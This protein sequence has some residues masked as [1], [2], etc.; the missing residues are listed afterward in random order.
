[1]TDAD[2]PKITVY[3]A[4]GYTGGLVCEE[5]ARRGCDFVAAG[6]SFESLQQLSSR[7]GEAHAVVPT[8]RSASLDALLGDTNV[9]INCAGPF[10]DAGPPVARAALRNDVH[11]LDTTGEQDY[12][13]WM[14]DEI[15][16]EAE[17][18]GLVFMP[19][20]AFEYATGT[21]V[22]KLAIDQGADQI[23]VCYGATDFSTS[24][25]TKMSIVR[26][27]AGDGFSWRGGRIVD[28]LTGG[29]IYE[30][31][32]PDGRTHTGAWMPG[33][34][35]ILVP[36]LAQVE[37]AESCVLIGGA[38]ASFLPWGAGLMKTAAQ[39]GKPLADR[40]VQW[41]ENR[42]ADEDEEAHPFTVVAFDPETVEWYAAVSGDDPYLATGRIIVEAATRLRN[43]EWEPA[44]M[45]SPPALFD[46][47]EFA[48]S[49]GLEV[50]VASR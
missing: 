38:L 29:R 42:E 13:K 36:D 41:L 18:R 27:I 6:R 33:G 21:L 43:E 5:L 45:L 26:S 35:P 7:I 11:Y 47:V 32:F 31:P 39:V 22:S 50:D 23:V 16:A 1:M 2:E 46:A 49:V 10:I 4:T 3:G 24:A 37:T 34:E 15:D 30:V 12:L 25:G 9:L 17:E 28:E 14:R 20:C 40:I 48:E 19:S 8:L 44:G